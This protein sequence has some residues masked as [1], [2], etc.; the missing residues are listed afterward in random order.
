MRTVTLH[1]CTRR[2]TCYDCDNKKCYHH[3]DKGADCP[4]YHCDNDILQDCEH[5]DFIESYIRVIRNDKAYKTMEQ[6]A[7][8]MS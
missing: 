5:C 3:G 4:K 7:E 1:D 8:G 6:M 2:T